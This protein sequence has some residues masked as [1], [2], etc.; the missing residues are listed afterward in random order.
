LTNYD[1]SLKVFKFLSLTGVKSV[2]VCAGARNA[3]LVMALQKQNFKVYS[4]FE[5]RSAAFFALGLIRASNTPVAVLTTS[6]TAVAELLPAAI[7][8]T[9]Q[10][11]PLILVSADRPKA[12]RGS[13]APQAIEQLGIF[14]SYVENT[15]DLDVNSEDFNFEWSLKKPIH[16]NIC[17]DEPLIDQ[18]SSVAT[19]TETTFKKKESKVEKLEAPQLGQKPV[20]I[21]GGLKPEEISSVIAFIQ[22]IKAPIYAEALSQISHLENL[23]PF[24][25]R[26]SDS[27]VKKA[28]EKNL[29]DSIIRIGS[30]PTLR[31][32]RDLESEYKNV[33][34]TQFSDLKFS[35]LSRPTTML[36][37]SNLEK[38][39]NRPT[40]KYLEDVRTLD[41][42]LQKEKISLLKKYP[43]SEP[44]LVAAL[45]E[46]TQQ[47]PIYLGNSLPIRHWD[48][49]AEHASSEVLANRGANGIDGQ[50]STYLGWSEKFTESFCLVGD[51]TA[52][53]DLVSLGLTP[54]LTS[55]K[56]RIVVLNNFG[57]QIFNR[58]LKNDL[59]INAH[60]TQFK[61][62]AEMWEWS[63]LLVKKKEDL[64]QLASQQQI[65]EI[66]PSAEQ[67]KMFWDDWDQLCRKA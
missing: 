27:L 58:V 61:A 45:S 23:S 9:Y 48:Q 35:G 63:Y 38:V 6:G 64:K 30:V 62:W 46:I 17:F 11:L 20:V 21:V 33:P 34:V 4:F 16:L 25:M 51:L 57:G 37:L 47:L 65:I 59:F 28:F 56:K 52:L 60:K 13:G 26:S 53:Y 44:A 54:Q 7:E 32:W 66:Q 39:T 3:P 36:N 55:S 67:T 42:N 22:K 15:W 14:S 31:F 19:K 50:I 5:E 49:F 29:C 40:E 24:L 41:Q 18:A 12:Y 43:E 1:L 8:A 2:V 10:G